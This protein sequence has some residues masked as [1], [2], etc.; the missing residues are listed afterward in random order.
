MTYQARVVA[1]AAEAEIRNLMQ[2]TDTLEIQ[3]TLRVQTPVTLERIEAVVSCHSLCSRTSRIS[4][5]P[6]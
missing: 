6:G 3:N 4:L 5:N 1:H 2:H